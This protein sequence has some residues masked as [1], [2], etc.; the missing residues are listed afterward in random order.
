MS[1][2]FKTADYDAALDLQ[3]SVR[4]VLPANHLARFVVDVCWLHLSS[5]RI[6]DVSWR[7]I[8]SGGT[9]HSTARWSI[10]R[11]VGP[12]HA[13]LCWLLL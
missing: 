6:L 1:R 5:V 3:V 8:D 13:M 9:P 11:H 12:T 7:M 2:K 4:E 10:N